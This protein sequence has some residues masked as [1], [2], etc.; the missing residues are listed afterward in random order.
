MT[1]RT[2]MAIGAHADDIEFNAGATLAKYRQEGYEIIYILATNNMS[3]SWNSLDD[4]GNRQVQMPAWY[5]IMPQRK[6][7]AAAAAR[8]FG[9]AAIHLDHPQRHYRRP[10]GVVEKL[11]FGSRSPEGL[12]PGTPTILMA[13]EDASCL[14]R[15]ADLILQHRPEAVLTHS[16]A[17]GNIEHVGCCLLASK[18]YVISRQAGY[19]GML[20]FWYDVTPPPVAGTKRQWDTFVDVTDHWQDKLDALALH[21][22]QIVD[23]HKLDLPHFG[24][25]CGCL[26]AEVF[27]IAERGS[28]KAHPVPPFSQEISGHE[29]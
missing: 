14:Q 13:H 17:T 27:T 18:S 29:N 15:L 3:G 7:E 5:E 10:D 16:M 12:A 2:L 23:V 9:T 1:N 19:G 25:A 28:S 11:C 24:A 4:M 21:A 6:K 20:L 26:H 22:C 8:F